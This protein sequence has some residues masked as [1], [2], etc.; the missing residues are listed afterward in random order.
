MST[1]SSRIDEDG[2]PVFEARGGPRWFLWKAY[3]NGQCWTRGW[4]IGREGSRNE[5]EQR[6]MERVCP[7]DRGRA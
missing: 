1:W 2:Q 7:E 6:V 5:A 3:R 4:W